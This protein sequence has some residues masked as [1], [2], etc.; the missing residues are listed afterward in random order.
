M[1]HVSTT[2]QLD[3]VAS[4]AA[5]VDPEEPGPARSEK[6]AAYY[7]RAARERE[8]ILHLL[9]SSQTQEKRP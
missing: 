3:D 7:A 4:L 1:L 5:R 6:L 8:R 2:G 9:S